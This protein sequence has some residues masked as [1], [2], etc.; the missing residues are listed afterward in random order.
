MALTVS[1]G[2]LSKV[3]TTYIVPIIIILAAVKF[4]A[5]SFY[6]MEMK[7][8]NSFWKAFLIIFIVA[9]SGAVLIFI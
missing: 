8:S 4:L 7:I 6:F 1:A 3:S 5:V 2:L 9:F